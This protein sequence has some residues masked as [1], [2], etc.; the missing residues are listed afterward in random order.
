MKAKNRLLF[1]IF[2][3]ALFSCG[4][5]KD[6]KINDD[7]E[8]S[9]RYY[10]LSESGWKSK[11]YD[12][13][14]DDL[15]FTATEVPLPYY[16]L[17]EIGSDD[18]QKVDSISKQNER[19][20]IIEFEFTHESAEDLLEKGVTDLEYTE[21]IKYISFSLEKDFYAVTSKNDTIPCSGLTFERNFKMAPYNK[22]ILFFTD[23]DPQE[24]IQL[25]YEDKL[26]KRGTLKFT[27]TEKISKLLL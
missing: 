20:R 15:K 11:K 23:I 8:V 14:I 21:A 24:E 13:Q 25:I 7:S 27:F 19:E 16:I 10:N 22:V 9:Y 2:L 26:F 3:C 12:Q 1:F 17:K 5:K 4:K 18:L 6:G